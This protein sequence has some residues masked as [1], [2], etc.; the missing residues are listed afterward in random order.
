MHFPYNDTPEKIEEV[1]GQKIEYLSIL[2][3]DEE[4][5]SI[6]LISWMKTSNGVWHRFFI[7]VWVLHRTEFN[8]KE[9]EELIEEDF[10]EGII[11]IDNEIW[12]VRN[13]MDEFHL[14]DKKILDAELI[15]FKKDNLMCCQLNI[16]TESGI[17][18]HFNDYGDEID[19]EILVSKTK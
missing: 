12:K 13:L 1:I 8:E 3:K 5:N 6:P 19:A 14:K 16:K 2:V 15:Y 17:T 11:K 18:L 9:K 4:P 10:E 7:D